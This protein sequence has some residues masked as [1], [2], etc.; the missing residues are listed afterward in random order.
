M[1]TTAEAGVIRFPFLNMGEYYNFFQIK[2]YKKNSLFLF[3]HH[4][5]GHGQRMGAPK[6]KTVLFFMSN[7]EL[8]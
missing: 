7:S 5:V 8:F 4:A 1:Q 6:T 2:R 3:L